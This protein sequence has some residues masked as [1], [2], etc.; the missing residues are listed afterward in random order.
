LPAA[1]GENQSPVSPTRKT[2]ELEQGW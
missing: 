1:S 2:W